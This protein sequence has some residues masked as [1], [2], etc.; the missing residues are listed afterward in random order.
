[1]TTKVYNMKSPRGHEVA[2]QFILVSEDKTT[3]QSYKSVV[4]EWNRIKEVLYLYGSVWDYSATTRKYFK[5]FVNSETSLNYEN[6]QKWLKE[7]EN[8]INIIEVQEVA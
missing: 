4:C 8:N 6:K 7:I 1:M 5:E 3:F 2:N